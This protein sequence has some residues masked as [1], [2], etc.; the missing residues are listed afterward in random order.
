M[1][2]RNSRCVRF[3]G[4]F[5]G[6]FRFALQY[7]C[8]LKNDSRFDNSDMYY[9]AH[10]SLLERIRTSHLNTNS[11]IR[12][13]EIH[14]HTLAWNCLTNCGKGTGTHTL[15]KRLVYTVWHTFGWAAWP[16]AILQTSANRFLS[17]D[18]C[19]P[20]EPSNVTVGTNDIAGARAAVAS[21]YCL[22][23]SAPCGLS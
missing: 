12:K 2:L 6:I 1:Q 9:L 18:A 11:S 4:F 16:P 10:V 3:M 23:S 20:C 13:T 17:I 19:R 5:G 14:T 15:R 8:Q 7:F 22:S 21:P